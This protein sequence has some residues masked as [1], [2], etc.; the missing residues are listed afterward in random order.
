MY[1]NPDGDLSA[2]ILNNTPIKSLVLLAE[3]YFR[4]HSIRYMTWYAFAITYS[5]PQGVYFSPSLLFQP[6][7]F[8]IL[9]TSFCKQN[10]NSNL[11]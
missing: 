11:A 9:I 1:K 4:L 8:N 6:Y 2:D 10:D 7:I 5:P 3:P